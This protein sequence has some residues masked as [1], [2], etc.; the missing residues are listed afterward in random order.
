MVNSMQS[1]KN[2]SKCQF[3]IATT[4]SCNLRLRIKFY[5]F[6]TNSKSKSESRVG[7]NLFLSKIIYC[8][9]KRYDFWLFNCVL[10]VISLSY[11]KYNKKTEC[12][13]F[14]KNKCKGLFRWWRCSGKCVVVSLSD[15]RCNNVAD[16]VWDVAYITHWN[17]RLQICEENKDKIYN[18]PFV[19]LFNN[20]KLKNTIITSTIFKISAPIRKAL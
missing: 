15:V 16:I 5:L 6:W 7:K 17:I 9:K 11:Y 3:F 4:N 1:N 19:M 20:G 13:R 18:C 14:A 8:N 10:W 2:M 12:K